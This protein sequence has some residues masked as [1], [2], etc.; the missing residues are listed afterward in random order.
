MRDTKTHEWVKHVGDVQ[1]VGICD[2]AQKE[3]GEIVFIELP[4]VGA[5]LK[6]GDVLC[7]IETTKAAAD[8]ICPI[9]GVV[10]AV[11]TELLERPGLINTSAEDLGWIAEIDK[12]SP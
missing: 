1:R 10:R 12:G 4:K 7:I 3:L 9:D 8:I 11:N 2:W 5:E 6:S